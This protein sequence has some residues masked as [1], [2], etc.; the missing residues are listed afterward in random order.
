MRK[1][2]DLSETTRINLKLVQV[3]FDGYRL[4][5]FVGRKDA[6]EHLLSLKLEQVRN[7]VF[8]MLRQKLIEFLGYGNLPPAELDRKLAESKFYQKAVAEF[9]GAVPSLLQEVR[10]RFEGPL[11]KEAAAPPRPA[12][13]PD[14]ETRG[15]SRPEAQDLKYWQRRAREAE[16]A[17]VRAQQQAQL[18]RKEYLAGMEMIRRILGVLFEAAREKGVAI[19]I[20]AAEAA[21]VL[22]PNAPAPPNP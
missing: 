8:G 13:K 15:V 5:S 2:A 16:E 12:G 19:H 22:P 20:N 1:V 4:P 7:E 14:G 18:E 17:A 11:L 6:F 9:E 3:V 21:R 10:S